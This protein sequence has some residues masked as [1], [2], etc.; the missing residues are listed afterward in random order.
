[1]NVLCKLL[2]WLPG[3]RTLNAKKA[4]LDQSDRRLQ[5]SLDRNRRNQHRIIRSMDCDRRWSEQAVNTAQDALNVAKRAKD[6]IDDEISQ[7]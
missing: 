3:A 5:E 1:M 6:L 2:E 4:E 7:V